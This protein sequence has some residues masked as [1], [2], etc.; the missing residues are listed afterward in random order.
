MPRRGFRAAPPRA[1]AAAGADRGRSSSGSPRRWTRFDAARASRRSDRGGASGDDACCKGEEFGQIGDLRFSADGLHLAYAAGEEK[2]E[3]QDRKQFLVVDGKRGEPFEGLNWGAPGFS[4]D[5]RRIAF[6]ARI[7]ARMRPIFDGEPGEEFDGVYDV[8]Y[9]AEGGH[10]FFLA[11]L[12]NLTFLVVDGKREA[13]YQDVDSLVFSPHGSGWAYRARTGGEAYVVLNGKRSRPYT[14][15]GW[16]AISPDGTR[17]AWCARERGMMSQ[18]SWF[19]VAGDRESEGFESIGEPEFSA[20][21]SAVEFQA[22]AGNTLW[23]R[24]MEVR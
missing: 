21:G 8:G 1:T 14:E 9:T 22:R 2:K 20:D 12:A 7:G 6:G 13:P 10:R 24:R 11:Q 15:V 19:L 5:G 3:G 16:L 4:P 23:R 17:A 18:G